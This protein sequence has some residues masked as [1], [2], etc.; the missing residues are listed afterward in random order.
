VAALVVAPFVVAG[1]ARLADRLDAV[2]EE[3]VHYSDLKTAI[4]AAGGPAALKRCGT[5]YTTRFDTQAVSYD[6]R[7]HLFEVQIFPVVP[8]TIVAAS[9]TALAR[10]PRFP[11]ALARTPAWTIASSCQR[12]AGGR[13]TAAG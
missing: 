9:T 1:A 11:H 8:G 6:L 3:S 2:R 12:P 13:R 7:V 4:R 5:V 10:D